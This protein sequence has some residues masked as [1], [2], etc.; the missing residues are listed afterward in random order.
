MNKQEP[1]LENVK[2]S[3]TNVKNV[4]SRGV[5]V[6]LFYCSCS[7]FNYVSFLTFVYSC[8]WFIF[9]KSF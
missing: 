7:M 5:L 9:M 3:E 2:S 1:K 6:L 8:F 4:L